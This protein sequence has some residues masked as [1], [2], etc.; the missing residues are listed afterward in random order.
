[1]LDWVVIKRVVPRAS[2]ESQCNRRPGVAPH[3]HSRVAGLG[4][5]EVMRA[6]A[7]ALALSLSLGMLGCGG[8]S[9]GLG[10]E[11]SGAG[12]DLTNDGASSAGSNAGS[13]N[14]CSDFRG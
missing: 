12:G 3:Q 2:S 10:A 7:L 9:G 1:L 8:Q 14:G 6:G 4:A 13:S 11:A 5:G